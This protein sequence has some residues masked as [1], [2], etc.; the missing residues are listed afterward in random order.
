MRGEVGGRIVTFWSILK[1][2]VEALQDP[3]RME[4]VL[5]FGLAQGGFGVLLD[6]C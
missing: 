6:A 4:S 3:R 2:G 1:R 5:E